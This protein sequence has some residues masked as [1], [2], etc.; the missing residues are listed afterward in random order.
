MCRHLAVFSRTPV[1]AASL[2]LDEPHALLEQ[3]CGD[4]RGKCH[5]D[6]WGIGWYEGY[7][8]EPR[9]K[10]SP[11][12]ARTDPAYRATIQ[13]V[14]ASKFIAHVRNASVGVPNVANSHPFAH[15]SWLFTH[16]GTL[17]GFEYLADRIAEETD[18]DLLASRRG[19]TDSE[20]I[21]YWL[22]TRIGDKVDDETIALE[23]GKAI[24]TL[25]GWSRDFPADEASKFNLLLTDGQSLWASRWQ[26]DLHWLEAPDR[27]MVASEPIGSG[28]WREVPEHSILSVDA[29]F[30][31]RLH[32]L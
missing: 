23:M 25:D 15:G 12:D 16:N 28:S 1:A 30:G 9:V 11:A 13:G 14:T 10:R 19:T 3:A 2:V 8:P 31:V 27:V 18:T 22:L 4:T 20:A 26:N 17:R 7:S 5:G 32:Q 21:F 24:A 29:A 6:G